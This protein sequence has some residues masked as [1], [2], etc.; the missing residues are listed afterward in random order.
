[1]PL[2][3]DNS[4]IEHL[5]ILD[6]IRINS[7]GHFLSLDEFYS[8]ILEGYTLAGIRKD[9]DKYKQATD[10]L[11]SINLTPSLLVNNDYLSDYVKLPITSKGQITSLKIVRN[12]TVGGQVINIEKEITDDEKKELES[13]F[14]LYD[15]DTNINKQSLNA[16]MDEYNKHDSLSRIAKWWVE[17][18]KLSFSFN[19]THVGIVLAHTNARRCDKN[20]PELPLNL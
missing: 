8:K 16:F 17:L 2:P 13:V 20:L 15:K 18:K 4:W 3:T 19:L 1:M 5:E 7:M 12:I 10:L 9:S 11:L 14:D 6:T